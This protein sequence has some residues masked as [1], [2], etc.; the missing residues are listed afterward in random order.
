MTTPMTAAELASELAPRFGFTVDP[1][2]S[3]HDHSRAAMRGPAGI[4]VTL[5]ANR[6]RL[7]IA[8]TTPHDARA[9]V[10]SERS[11][12]TVSLRRTIDDIEREMRRRLLPPLT[13]AMERHRQRVRAAD[14]REAWMRET[15]ADVSAVLREAPALDV[16][17][18]NGD[19]WR[20]AFDVTHYTRNRT[21]Y[22]RWTANPS[23]SVTIELA[24]I[25]RELAIALAR[26]I[27]DYEGAR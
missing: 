14:E 6:D 26:T 17:T 12:I 11:E 8:G 27:A 3:S 24:H 16:R 1:E 23:R 9:Q 20:R 25:P 2:W 15:N 21:H 19:G 5:W 22:G 18:D 7:A 4:H 10:F 13:E